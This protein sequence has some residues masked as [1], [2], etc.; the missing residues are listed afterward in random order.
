MNTS[1]QFS[2]HPNPN[3]SV[4]DLIRTHYAAVVRL[5]TAILDDPEDA[6]DAAQETFIQL[7]AHL[8][9]FRGEASLKT[10]LFSIAINICRTELRK[11]RRQNLLVNAIWTGIQ[12]NKC[13]AAFFYILDHTAAI[14]QACQGD[15]ISDGSNISC[16]TT[17]FKATAQLT[18]NLVFL[19]L[20]GKET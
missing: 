9:E 8:P 2:T 10:W 13:P 14:I 5:A 20:D 15:L 6:E 7:A 3:G 18:D 1:E 12:A 16:G 19:R 17:L 4:D 11:R